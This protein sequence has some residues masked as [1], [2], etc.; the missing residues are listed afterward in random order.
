MC[1]R[2]HFEKEAQAYRSKLAEIFENL[3]LKSAEIAKIDSRYIFR[4]KG[5]KIG[6]LLITVT[7]TLTFTRRQ[8]TIFAD[9]KIEGKWQKLKLQKQVLC[10]TVK[11]VVGLVIV[12]LPF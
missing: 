12:H 1:T 3:F 10:H 7:A 9:R 11:R 6:L 2:P 4:G 5:R 8:M